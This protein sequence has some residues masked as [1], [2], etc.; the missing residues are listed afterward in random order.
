MKTI[1]LAGL[2]VVFQSKFLAA[3]N[4]ILNGGFET[5]TLTTSVSE[6]EHANVFDSLISGVFFL[7]GTL[8]LI[9]HDGAACVD[10]L[11][12]DWMIADDDDYYWGAFGFVLSQTL[13]AGHTYQLNFSDQSC[14]G[15]YG[16]RWIEIGLSN[17]PDQ[18]GDVVAQIIN[19]F[20]SVWTPQQVTFIPSVDKTFLTVKLLEEYAGFDSG[21]HADDFSLFEMPT[22]IS[23]INSS[24]LSLFPNPAHITITLQLPIT[25]PFNIIIINTLGEEVMRQHAAAPPSS[26]SLNISSLAEG[27]YFVVVRSDKQVFTSKFIKE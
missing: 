1:L 2:L 19:G 7:E 12:G 22:G 25:N 6:I 26:L 16:S 18:I 15:N 20:D 8:D 10:P 21:L 3:Q 13:L 5:N 23:G 4:L 9:T 11:Q 24:T 27:A 14:I 17:N